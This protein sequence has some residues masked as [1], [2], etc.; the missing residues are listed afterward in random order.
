MWKCQSRCNMSV[1]N[2][3]KTHFDIQVIFANFVDIAPPWKM[4]LEKAWIVIAVG[5]L[6]GRP[7]VGILISLCK[8]NMRLIFGSCLKALLTIYTRGG[9]VDIIYL[10]LGSWLLQ[11]GSRVPLPTVAWNFWS[12]KGTAI[13]FS[14][15]MEESFLGTV[16]S[17]YNC[18]KRFHAYSGSGLTCSRTPLVQITLRS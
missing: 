15:W 13:F 4:H 5:E 16:L 14:L 8:T 17:L 1:R 10:Q 7:T 6:R 12:G 18:R 3:F 2:F 9:F 11:S